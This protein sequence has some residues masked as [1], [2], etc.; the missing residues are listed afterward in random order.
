MPDPL[1]GTPGGARGGQHDRPLPAAAGRWF[2]GAALYAT[3]QG[4]TW[5]LYALVSALRGRRTVPPGQD[6]ARRVPA[7]VV[8]MISLLS[9]P[10]GGPGSSGASTPRMPPA[11]LLGARTNLCDGDLS[12]AGAPP[13]RDARAGRAQRGAPEGARRLWASSLRH[14]GESTEPGPYPAAYRPGP[15]AR[16]R[17]VLRPGRP[18]PVGRGLCPHRAARAGDVGG[19]VGGL[20]PG[21]RWRTTTTWWC[22]SRSFPPPE[23]PAWRGRRFRP[24]CRRSRGP[25][26]DRPLTGGI[27]FKRA[28]SSPRRLRRA[29]G[30]GLLQSHTKAGVRR[31]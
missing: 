19:L 31:R 7:G 4:L 14:L 12:A 9:A 6:T 21:S 1:H 23:R 5:G 24:G 22:A 3:V 27:D 15:R 2:H 10:A 13:G 28:P 18:A 26:V 16:P 25:R 8:S 29:D 11:L 17:L 20:P 30:A